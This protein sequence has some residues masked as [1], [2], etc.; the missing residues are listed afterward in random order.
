MEIGNWENQIRE[1]LPLVPGEM[2]A[3][4]GGRLSGAQAQLGSRQPPSCPKIQMTSPSL[5]FLSHHAQELSSSVFIPAFSEVPRNE[6]KMWLFF[7]RSL[8]SFDQSLVVFLIE[9]L[10][11]VCSIYI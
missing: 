7:G 4:P 8:I 11:E 6:H 1:E 3:F 5:L 9:T 2:D 10:S